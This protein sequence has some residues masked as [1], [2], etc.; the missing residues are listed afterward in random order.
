MD[1]MMERILNMLKEAQENLKAFVRKLLSQEC[2]LED[3]TEF[4]KDEKNL[5]NPDGTLTEEYE[6]MLEKM[7]EKLSSDKINQMLIDSASSP[8]EADAIR[9]IIG[10]VEERDRLMEDYRTTITQY[11][12]DAQAW[13]N[14]R[15]T[16]GL[17]EEE[18]K[19]KIKK[20]EDLLN[21]EED[22]VE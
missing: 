4:L 14:D 21:S 8:E 3:T 2:I 9:D 12:E 6:A 7:E 1:T 15:A 13:M 18:K 5:Y 17:D 22:I 20:I 10:F 19:L 16:E 11:D